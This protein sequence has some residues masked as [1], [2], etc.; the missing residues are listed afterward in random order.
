FA[1]GER[2]RRRAGSEQSGESHEDRAMTRHDTPL[3][4]AS[5]TR[6]MKTNRYAGRPIKLLKLSSAMLRR[7]RTSVAVAEQPFVVPV[8]VPPAAANLQRPTKRMSRPL[9]TWLL[10]ERPRRIR[11]FRSGCLS[12]LR[13]NINCRLPERLFDPRA[14]ARPADTFSCSAPKTLGLRPVTHRHDGRRGIAFSAEPR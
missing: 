1:T 14:R 4:A 10:Y 6:R 8:A 2:R 9:C 5:F 13:S 7:V 3:Q 11:L 12:E